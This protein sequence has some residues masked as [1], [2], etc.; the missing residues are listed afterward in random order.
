MRFSIAFWKKDSSERDAGKP[1]RSKLVRALGSAAYLL[2]V[3]CV[4]YWC[5]PAADR[6]LGWLLPISPW[7]PVAL[8]SLAMNEKTIQLY[9]FEYVS[10]TNSKGLRGDEIPPK[11]PGVFRILVLGDSYVYGWGVNFEDTWCER[12]NHMFRDAGRTIEV[13]N[14]GMLGNGPIEYAQRA[15]YL[16]PA[17]RPDLVLVSILQGSDIME[18]PT[19]MSLHP[20]LSI[21]VKDWKYRT[22][23]ATAAKLTIETRESTRKDAIGSAMDIFQRMT[24]EQRQRFDHLDDTVKRSFHDGLLNSGM[25]EG[26]TKWP[27]WYV[28]LTENDPYRTENK[29]KALA[30]M[31]LRIRRIAGRHEGRT[32][33]VLMPEGPFVNR[34]A[35]ANWGRIGFDMAPELYGNEETK[36]LIE[37]SSKKAGIGFL[38]L[39]PAF[40]EN[41]D[42]TGLF[43]V[44]DTH[45]TPT[46]HML[47]AQTLFTL[48]AKEIP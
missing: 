40:L 25:I 22:P 4:L 29:T 33:S 27:H 5:S 14:G 44:L 34:D 28:Q 41:G 9:D 11:K 17:L 10:R 31:F 2:A 26:A 15:E 46:G 45:M 6:L 32:C 3:T 16:I 48:L 36:R 35:L 43:F 47:V 37:A 39:A 18:T 20:N 19:E 13:I 12:L 1:P 24:P 42:K 23:P 21:L 8:N 38:D 7:P 30:A